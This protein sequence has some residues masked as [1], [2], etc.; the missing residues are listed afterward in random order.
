MGKAL[1]QVP[2]EGETDAALPVSTVVSQQQLT[3]LQL[4]EQQIHS[5]KTKHCFEKTGGN[6][7]FRELAVPVSKQRKAIGKRERKIVFLRIER[8]LLKE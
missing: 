1:G 6:I 8:Q 7:F 5:L 2:P 3:L 4:P